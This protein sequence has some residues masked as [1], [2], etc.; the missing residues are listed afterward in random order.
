[1]VIHHGIRQHASVHFRQRVIH[2][3]HV[4]RVVGEDLQGLGGIPGTE[5]PLALGRGQ[6]ESPM[7]HGEIV[8][9]ERI[10]LRPSR[11]PAGDEESLYNGS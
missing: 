9:T 11:L 7:E 2:Q 10:S 4:H 6:L 5:H 3:H 1:M 8:I